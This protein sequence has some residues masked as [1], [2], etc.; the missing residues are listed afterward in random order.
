M[1]MLKAFE[2]RIS[3]QLKY[4]VEW[5]VEKY[6]IEWIVEKYLIEWI[7]EKYLIE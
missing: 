6:L 5:V 4:P 3:N 1:W 7:V 2:M